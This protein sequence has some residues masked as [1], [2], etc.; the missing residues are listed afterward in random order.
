[1]PE[2]FPVFVGLGISIEQAPLNAVYL[3]AGAYNVL[4]VMLNQHRL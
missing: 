3:Y 2:F 1:M 4:S